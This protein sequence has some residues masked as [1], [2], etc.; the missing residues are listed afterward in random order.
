MM[1]DRLNGLFVAAVTRL[2]REEK[3]QALT[4][5]ALVLA[6]IVVGIVASMTVLKTGIGDKITALVSAIAGA[7]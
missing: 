2:N 5:Y 3:G 1:V 6:V 7:V 4:E